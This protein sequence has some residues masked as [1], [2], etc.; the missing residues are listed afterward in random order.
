MRKF[1]ILAI[2]IL[3][4]IG[5]LFLSTRPMA[6]RVI[7]DDVEITDEDGCSRITIMFNFPVQYI[8]HFPDESGED[9][10]IQLEPI[11][12]GSQER[13]AL[14]THETAYLP[15]DGVGELQDITYEGDIEGGPYLTLFFRTPV[16]FSVS[17]G[18][19]FRS[20]DVAVSA[21]GASTP[22]IFAPK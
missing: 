21:I 10:R 6:G 1:S 8:Q 13:D 17:Q 11:V 14:F 18:K 16:K 20:L 3:A 5:V 12:T 9:L 15:T 22:C 4:I 7:I 19:N 2:C